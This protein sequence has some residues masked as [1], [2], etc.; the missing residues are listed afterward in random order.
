MKTLHGKRNVFA[1]R[2]TAAVLIALTVL[3][4]TGCGSGPAS[5]NAAAESPAAPPP[6]TTTVK[7]GGNPFEVAGIQDPHKFLD[8]FAAVKE[9]IAKDDKV[10]VANH[11]LYPLRVNEADGSHL[12][13]ETRADLVKQYDAI[14]TEKVKKAIARQSADDLFVNYQGVMV[15]NGDLWFGGSADT[16]QVYGLIAVNHDI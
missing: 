12:K 16:P 4:A 13:I 8:M 3:S 1:Y 7:A 10:T 5:N 2:L 11:I 14:F 15:G 9:A 6:I